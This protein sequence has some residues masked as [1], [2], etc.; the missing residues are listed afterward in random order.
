MEFRPAA[1]IRQR[2]AGAIAAGTP[3]IVLMERAGSGLARATLRLLRARNGNDALLVAGRGNNGGDLI[4]A[5]HLLTNWG[6]RCQLRLLLPPA[7]LKGTAREAWQRYFGDAPST[8]TVALYASEADWHNSDPALELPPRGVVV[9]G[10][11]GTGITGRPTATVAAAIGWIQRAA[12]FAAIVAAD[13]PSGLDADSGLPAGLAPGADIP[14]DYPVV[15]A[16]LTVTF[17]SPKLGF[18]QPA[19]SS[20]LG[21]VE[22][23]AIGL[24]ADTLSAPPPHPPC[25]LISANT[26]QPLLRLRPRESHKGSYAA[27][28]IIG[29]AKGMSG[30]PALTA[31]G[32]LR[33]GAGRVTAVVPPDAVQTVSNLAPE[34]LI[35]GRPH[36]AH[37]TLALLQNDLPAHN[38]VVLGPGLGQAPESALLVQQLVKANPTRLLLDADALNLWSRQQPLA[39]LGTPATTIIT[40]HPGEAARL[41]GTTVARVQQD[42]VAAVQQLA[43]RSNSVVVLKGAG[44]LVAAPGERPWINLT[45][46]PGMATVGSGDVLAGVIAAL[47]GEGLTSLEAALLG[48]YLHATAGDLAAWHGGM[49][50]LLARDLAA[51][52]AAARATLYDGVL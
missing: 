10:L 15:K 8:T 46:N 48:V 16:D 26:L 40:P 3:A 32:A 44:T 49:A 19:A 22:A 28:L 7:G 42:R 31:L 24:A 36:D 1:A 47:W 23:V 14:P 45:G 6:V 51:N 2:E 37:E 27:A 29:G 18:L 25:R 35:Y 34:A 20:W 33:A 17:D 12:P 21:R 38:V 39:P 50:A 41:L 4:V 30:A 13:L 9:D 43:S 5:A 52:L 11:L